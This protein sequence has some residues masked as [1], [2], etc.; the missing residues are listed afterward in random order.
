[1][2]G[3][4]QT[5]SDQALL[6]AVEGEAEAMEAL[7]VELVEAPT[8]LGNEEPGQ[9]LMSDAFA[10]CGL[11]PVDVPL[12]AQ[13]LRAHPLASPFTWEVAGKRNVVATWAGV[14]EGRSLVLNG[15]IDVVPPAAEELWTRPPYEAYR[16]GEWLVG[17]GSGDMKAGLAAIVGAVRGLRRLGL[18]P[19]GDVMLQSV[20]EE[21]CGGNGAV[22]CLIAGPTPDAV[23][24]TEPF[25]R[26]VLVS[27]VGVLWFHV[28]IAGL[29]AH[30]GSATLG[31]NAIEVSFPIV[32]AL[33]ELEREMNQ[34][35]PPPYD[36]FPHPI[37]LNVGMVAGGDWTSTVAAQC[38]LS[39]RF[40][41]YP[42]HPIADL[43][44]R[45]EQTVARA[46]A[47]HPFLALHPPIVRY[48]GFVV[49]GAEVPAD[50]P[51]VKELCRVAE[52]V[53][54][55]SVPTVPS[56]ATTDARVFILGGVPAVCLGPW[57]ENVHGVDER[58]HI[59][60]MVETAQTLALLIRNWCGLTSG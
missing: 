18:A 46:C 55:E 51:I 57:A 36:Q 54:G 27:Q 31:E 43:Q 15:H 53:S 29:P 1:V 49:E 56:T 21:E 32:T 17:R 11:E 9:A 45:V 48:D 52:V 28:D 24:I 20:V 16:Q 40:A 60:S 37:N 3:T 42:G 13:A 30:A 41:T 12:D 14:G 59:G 7:L 23:V 19:L 58:V 4:S 6:D 39:C 44:R 5:V 34:A 10:G 50:T 35:P 47:G 33:R 22:Q 2:S 25:P 26:A 8:V 38:T